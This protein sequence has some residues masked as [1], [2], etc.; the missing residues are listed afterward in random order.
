MS[1]ITEASPSSIYLMHKYFGKKPS[2][3]IKNIVKKYPKK[4]DSLLDPF[5]GYGG[6]G[7]EGV[8]LDRR[9]ILNDLNPIANFISDCILNPNVDMKLVDDYLKEIKEEYKQFSYHFR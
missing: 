4:G 9:V 2:L 8:L 6:L 1:N 5:S 3:E 7:I